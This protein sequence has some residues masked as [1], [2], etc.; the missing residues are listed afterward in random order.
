MWS[1][2]LYQESQVRRRLGRLAGVRA[3]EVKMYLKYKRGL[4]LLGSWNV[5]PTL[6][7]PPLRPCLGILDSP[8][9]AIHVWSV[10]I[11]PSDHHK[12]LFRFGESSRRITDPFLIFFPLPRT[13]LLISLALATYRE[14][15]F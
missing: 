2:A 9:F 13:A 3:V 11:L 5:A 4:R 12:T 10:Q 1:C 15:K 7:S 14:L 6:A 8:E